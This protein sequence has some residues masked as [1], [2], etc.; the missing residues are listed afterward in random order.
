M[1]FSPPLALAAAML[2]ACLISAALCPLVIA[3]GVLD[4]PDRVRKVQKSPTPTSGGLAIAA[5]LFGGLGVLS[6][7]LSWATPGPAGL[8]LTNAAFLQT[9]AALAAGML[10]LTIGAVDDAAPLPARVKFGAVAVIGLAFCVFAARAEAFPIGGAFAIELGF[11]G[12]LL[13]S[14]LWF[15]TVVNAVNFMDGANGLAMGCTAIALA[16]LGCVGLLNAAPH[17]AV[18]AFCAAAAMVGFLVWN[19]PKGALFA[20]D[21]GSLMAGGL[22]GCVGLILAQ[23]AGI[24]PVVAAI[25]FFPMLADVLLTLAWRVGQRRP[26]LFDGHREHLFQIGM[27]AGMS[28]QRAT[29]IYWAITAHC[30]LIAV[31]VAQAQKIAPQALLRQQAGDLTQ[32]EQMQALAFAGLAWLAALSPY[33]A[34]AVLAGIS[35]KVAGKV[36]AFARTRGL[37]ASV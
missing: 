32:A 16:A 10:L 3:A 7:L 12:G 2:A 30:G 28:H 1:D 4:A 22:G 31:L 24:S 20:G 13:G 8:G 14:S 34:L 19:F 23:E 6:V 9:A 37:D 15:F 35:M 36:R 33:I 5:G 29:L 17:A 25:A 26:N 21:A 18:L 11:W 27:R